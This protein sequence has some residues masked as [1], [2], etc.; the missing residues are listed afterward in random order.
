MLQAL[1]HSTMTEAQSGSPTDQVS[2]VQ[3]FLKCSPMILTISS[4]S[5]YVCVK[6]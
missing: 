1:H 4:L 2:A 3:S 5:Y 6:P